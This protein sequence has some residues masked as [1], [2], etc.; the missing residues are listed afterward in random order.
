MSGPIVLTWL[1][2]YNHKAAILIHLIPQTLIEQL[3]CTRL[4]EGREK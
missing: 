2:F 3:L 4:R 1:E